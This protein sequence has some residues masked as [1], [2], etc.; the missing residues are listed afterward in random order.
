MI[1]V[2]PSSSA[3]PKKD[4]KARN[5]TRDA[6]GASILFPSFLSSHMKT[7]GGTSR[8]AWRACESRHE[9]LSVSGSATAW[10]SSCR[11]QQYWGGTA[12]AA[13]STKD[14]LLR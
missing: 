4:N 5:E 7:S 8:C 9:G 1:D 6:R 14:S 10:S 12:R 11:G 3:E 2:R 13:S